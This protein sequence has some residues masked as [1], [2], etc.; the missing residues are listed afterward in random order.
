VEILH[1]FSRDW[2]EQHVDRNGRVEKGF[3]TLEGMDT[4]LKDGKEQDVQ[5]LLEDKRQISKIRYVPSKTIKTTVEKKIVDKVLPE[6][7]RGLIRGLNGDPDV[8]VWLEWDWVEENLSKQFIGFIRTSRNAGKE[9]YVRIPEGAAAD[10]TEHMSQCIQLNSGSEPILKYKRKGD[11]EDNDRSCVLKSAASA[12]SYLGYDRLAFIL[13]NN[14]EHGKKNEE[15]FEYF[16]HCMDSKHLWPQERKKIQFAKVKKGLSKWDIIQDS[17]NYVMCLIGVQSSDH[18]TD[19]AISIVGKWIFDSNFETA[20]PLSKESLDLCCSSD[21]KK[22]TF[23]GVTRVSV[24]K[25][26]NSHKVS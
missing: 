21:S 8:F 10:H 5:Y 20:L 23:E 17:Q 25:A 18:K 26:M 15:G 1:R 9:G 12:M 4:K 6:R 7:W 19:H 11:I 13:C 2:N 22:C 14:L 24:L 3:L 16:Q